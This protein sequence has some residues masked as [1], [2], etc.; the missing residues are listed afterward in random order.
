MGREI[1]DGFISEVR[2]Q[3]LEDP[4]LGISETFCGAYFRESFLE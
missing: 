4:A 3:L 1:L 2:L